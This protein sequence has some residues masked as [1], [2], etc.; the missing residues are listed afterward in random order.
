MTIVLGPLAWFVAG[1]SWFTNIIATLVIGTLAGF[2]GYVYGRF[3]QHA[4]N[5]LAEMTAQRDFFHAELK[6]QVEANELAAKL[7]AE[8]AKRDETNKP[9]E[10]KIDQAIE[11]APVVRGCV[12]RGFLDGLR[13]LQ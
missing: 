10:A 2:G 8:A 1:R 11:S 9:I 5:Q 6:R 3:D 7:A 13:K 4:A 12:P